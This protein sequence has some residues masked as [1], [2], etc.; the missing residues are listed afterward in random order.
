MSKARGVLRKR[1]ASR[2]AMLLCL[3]AAACTHAA[4]PKPEAA[5]PA[6]TV[7]LFDNLGAHHH[8]ITTSSPL[9]QQYFDQGL[10]LIYAFN[11]DEAIRAFEQAA[12]LDP[13]CAM[14]YWGIGFAHGP[15]YNLPLDSERNQAAYAAT[16]KAVAAAAHVSA[17]EQAYIH[18]LAR[19][20]SLDPNADRKALDRDFADGMREVAQRY[21]DDTDAATLYAE[22]MMD[23]RPWD[24]WRA[25]G[26]PQPGTIEIVATLEGVLQKDPNHPGANHYYIHAVEAS[27]HPD[28]ALAS[29]QRV[30]TLMPGAGHLVH[31]PSH[32]YM[33]VGRYN[34]AAQSNREAIEVDRAYIAE[35]QP[36]GVYPMMYYPHNIHFLWAAASMA[37]R[38]A[39]ALQAA[40]QVVQMAS[41]EMMRSMP[42]MEYFAPTLLFA[43]A[44]FGRWDDILEQPAPPADLQYAT[45]MWHYARGL[46]LA[47]RGQT[48]AA[49]EEEA[50]L[51]AIAAAMPADRT[52]GDNTPAKAALELAAQTLAGEIALARGRTGEALRHFRTAV[53]MQDQL[54]YSEPPP[55]YYPVRQSLGA[56]LLQAQR[57]REAEVVY[58]EDLERNPENGW[59]L[60]GLAA[61]LRAQGN[62]WEA[63]VVETRFREAWA[64]ADV[65]LTASRF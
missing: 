33:R 52:V 13:D 45:G 17:A 62:D 38:S 32:I 39:E 50:K 20:Y 35:V 55:W 21:P 22:S 37:G 49:A 54:P 34:A 9:A 18:A 10:R 57:P 2:H 53:R 43:Q 19:R 16:Q 23:L 47:A 48:K 28:R 44:R 29:A 31:M 14:A 6:P 65:Q 63:S 11:H 64:G 61:S 7:P 36:Q 24:L 40:Q 42:P 1:S 12:R 59:S 15:N 25:D 26:Q 27:P 58:R 41:P 51:A 46:A 30:G 3:L 5:S 60:Y 56:A 4:R 8:A